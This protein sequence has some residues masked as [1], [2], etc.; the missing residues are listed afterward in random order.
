MIIQNALLESSTDPSQVSHHAEQPSASF[1]SLSETPTRV[2]VPSD[3]PV[4]DIAGNS[5]GQATVTGVTVS[6]ASRPVS[7]AQFRQA[8]ARS[9]LA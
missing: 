5:R 3:P 6:R 2:S 9:R 4:Q 7:I 1:I 8:F